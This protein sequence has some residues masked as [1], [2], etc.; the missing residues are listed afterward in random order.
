MTTVSDWIATAVATAV[1]AISAVIA[2]LIV[3]AGGEEQAAAPPAPAASTRPVNP[4]LALAR[5]LGDLVVGVR[6]Q[7]GGPVDVSV[8]PPDLRPIPSDD[9]AISVGGRAA[10]AASCGSNCWRVAAAGAMRGR[11][12]TLAVDVEHERGRGQS[13]FRLPSRPPANGQTL[14]RRATRATGGVRS[15]HVDETLSSGRSGIRAGFDY[16]PPD[17]MRYTSSD[18]GR[19]VV[20]GNRR[21]DFV[22]G[23]WEASPA[24]IV[25]QPTSMWSGARFAR[26]LGRSR[27]AGRPVR[28][29]AAFRPDASYPAWFRLY[30]GERDRVL[31]AEMIAPAHFMLDRFSR[32]D[33]PA[34]IVPPT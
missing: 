26:S 6:A 28:V 14:L 1:I 4:Q 16:M 25:P 33:A 20:I 19:G 5:R 17:R 15:V 27:W 12:E 24:S 22:S 18:G 9:V 8:I 30:V 34:R 23:R 29:V 32:Y 21:W 31:A 11:G 13:R 2:S 10:Q 7:A 3:S